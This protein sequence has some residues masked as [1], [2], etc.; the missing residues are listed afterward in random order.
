MCKPLH[1]FSYFLCIF[2]HFLNIL[3]G[4][5]CVFMGYFMCF[6]GEICVVLVVYVVFYNIIRVNSCYSWSCS[7]NM[8]PFPLF[9]VHIKPHLPSQASGGQHCLLTLFKIIMKKTNPPTFAGEW[10]LTNKLR[11]KCLTLYI[12]SNQ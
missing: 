10:A 1:T 3:R 8:Y 5:F 12:N 2:L 9:G 11:N 6:S 4:Y 7:L